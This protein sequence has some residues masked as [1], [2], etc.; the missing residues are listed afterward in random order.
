VRAEGGFAYGAVGADIHVFGDGLPLYLLENWHAAPPA[1]PQFL[2][3]LPSRML[4]ARFAVVGFTGRERETLE[5]N[6]WCNRG[7]RRATRLLHAPGGQGKTRLADRLAQ[8]CRDAGWKV[9]TA[10][11]G[12]GS[13]LPPPGSQDLSTGDAP[14]LLMLVDYAD[15][16]PLSHLAWLFS[17]ALLHRDT[18]LIRVL[19]IARSTDNWP[20]L[21]GVLA[22]EQIGTSTQRL[23]DLSSA[24]GARA[25][26]FAAARDDFA[27]R[28]AVA[29]PAAIEPPGSLDDPSFGLTLA[30]H[31]AALAA[32]DAHQRGVRPPIDP[33]ALTGYLLDR[34]QAHWTRLHGDRKRDLL[35]RSVFTAAITGPV[36]RAEGTAAIDTLRLTTA[37]G[38]VLTD[39]AACYPPTD[40]TRDTVLE[41]L[42]PD[43]L[44]EDFVAL[45]LPGHHHGYPTQ[46]W[47]AETLRT[48]LTHRRDQRGLAL[49]V[50]AADRWPHVGAR[51]LYPFLRENPALAIQAGSPVLTALANLP[52]LPEELIEDLADAL[53][54]SNPANLELGAAALGVRRSR[55][56][57]SHH[58]DPATRARNQLNLAN[59][60]NQLARPEEALDATRQAVAT[61]RELVSTAAGTDREQH[62]QYLAQ[63]LTNLSHTLMR[64]RQPAEALAS[65]L[66]AVA[67][68]RARSAGDHLHDLALS[69]S[70]LGTVLQSVGQHTHALETLTEAVPLYEQLARTD[71]SHEFGLAVALTNLGGA[72]ARA[73]EQAHAVDPTRRA[74]RIW[75]QLAEADPDAYESHLA[76]SLSNLVSL[77]RDTDRIEDQLPVVEEAVAILRRLT[78]ANPHAYRKSYAVALGLLAE[79]QYRPGQ[80][81]R[82]LETAREAAAA[83]RDLVRDEPTA[84]NV[85][86]LSEALQ[87]LGTIAAA[88]GRHGEA[89]AAHAE[90]EAENQTWQDW[91]S[92]VGTTHHM[93]PPKI[94]ERAAQTPAEAQTANRLPPVA[95][96]DEDPLPWRTTRDISRAGRELAR[97][98]LWPELWKLICAVPLPNACALARRLPLDR[99]TLPGGRQAQ[100]LA[101]RLAAIDLRRATHLVETADRPAQAT[102]FPLSFAGQ[103]SFAPGGSAVARQEFMRPDPKHTSITVY[104]LASGQESEVFCGRADHRSLACLGT[105]SVVAVREDDTD[106]ATLV[107]YHDGHV[108][109]LLTGIPVDNAATVATAYGIVAGLDTAPVAF[110]GTPGRPLH[111]ANLSSLGLWRANI[112]AVDPSGTRLAISDGTTVAVVDADLREVYAVAE[113]PAAL[114]DA[115]DLAFSSADELLIA[116]T[117]R[118]LLLGQLKSG[119][120]HPIAAVGTPSLTNLFSVPAWRAVGGWALSEGTAY[121]LDDRTLHRMRPPPALAGLLRAFTASPDGRYAV[122]NSF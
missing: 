68:N 11:L 24:S 81:P 30:V 74:V 61:W 110:A 16:W 45:T 100:A 84:K 47:A 85:I 73:G 10:T 8:Q 4:N 17:N 62:E 29:D 111:Q 48:L 65:L 60:L 71:P 90:A 25:Q 112:L 34:E 46:P 13:V 5:L 31:T 69:L 88:A 121:F 105:R 52:D 64:V 39:H 57:L 75:R 54:G 78:S 118:G 15:R 97:R 109:P 72:L 70:N 113:V 9:T 12:P 58:G 103:L 32:V 50:A 28:Y 94:V 23:P 44:A 108:Q 42:Y 56:I 7:P 26:M 27:A 67:I 33:I 2:M 63:S 18:L 40:P 1:D 43:R 86:R 20:A 115:A 36:S 96:L 76:L 107:W 120:L 21:R 93:A 95:D 99:C 55:E 37:S 19:L 79:A 114:G 77:L 51:H 35:N 87:T 89:A 6:E 83:R 92:R 116:G 59:H 82:A 102:S 101:H 98:K 80:F 22:N 3:D 104:D 119:E 66:E 53:P 106:P 38:E 91:V 14:G 122:H 117:H 49:L 41:P